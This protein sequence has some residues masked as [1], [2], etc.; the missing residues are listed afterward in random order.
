MMVRKMP[1]DI[2][3]EQF[4]IAREPRG[5]RPDHRAR[6]AVA[7]VP[8][9]AQPGER[10]RVEPVEIGKQP[11]HV[12]QKDVAPLVMAAGSSSPFEP[13]TRR[14]DTTKLDQVRAEKRAALPYKLEAV[15][16]G[17]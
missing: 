4:M 14:G 8:A 3:K 7:R 6:R 13:L 16:I 9:H 2:A 12:T 10:R 15:V 1:V 17:G 11:V 5:Q